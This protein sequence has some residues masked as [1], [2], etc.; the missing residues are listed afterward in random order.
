[1]AFIPCKIGGGGGINLVGLQ[2]KLKA[3]STASGNSRTY[4]KFPIDYINKFKVVSKTGTATYVRYGWKGEGT[5]SNDI[6]VNTVYT[7]P[8]DATELSFFIQVSN[9]NCEITIEIVE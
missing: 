1:M 6:T 9:N 5:E 7:K 4:G 3:Y 2:F 8:S